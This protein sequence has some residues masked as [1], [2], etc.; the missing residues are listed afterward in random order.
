MKKTK[1]GKYVFEY[2]FVVDKDGYINDF[3]GKN[4]YLACYKDRDKVYFKTKNHHSVMLC[5]SINQIK[6]LKVDECFTRQYLQSKWFWENQVIMIYSFDN[7]SKSELVSKFPKE[8]I[9]TKISILEQ[10]KKEVEHQYKVKEVKF[11]SIT[12]TYDK[13]ISKIN[14][15]LELLKK[16]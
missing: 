5:K 10:R 16:V 4:K 13:E 15:E 9:N 2:L 11:Q 7:L 14:N 12:D 6:S 1:Y 8:N 3:Y